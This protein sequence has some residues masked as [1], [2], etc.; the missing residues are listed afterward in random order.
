MIYT[1]YWYLPPRGTDCADHVLFLSNL[2]SLCQD[3]IVEI[4]GVMPCAEALA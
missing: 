4:N 2:Q 1:Q 3:A